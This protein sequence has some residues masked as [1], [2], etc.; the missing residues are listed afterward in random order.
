MNRNFLS[1]AAIVCGAMLFVGCG[2]GDSR[3]YHPRPE[4]PS[5]AQ[6]Q[7]PAPAKDAS[8]NFS[9]TLSPEGVGEWHLEELLLSTRIYVEGIKVHARESS[10]EYFHKSS[11]E[12]I[13]NIVDVTGDYDPVTRQLK[14]EYT[15]MNNEKTTT[16][17]YEQNGSGTMTGTVSEDGKT[18]A[19]RVE[20]EKTSRTKEKGRELSATTNKTL[21]DFTVPIK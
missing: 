9:F 10:R 20:G 18:I 8:Q 7:A 2:Y 19:V 3:D 13:Y 21:Y 16:L 17:V 12:M 11:V 14:A 15:V 4:S 5:S 1:L 6:S